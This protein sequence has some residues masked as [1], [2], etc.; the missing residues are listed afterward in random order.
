MLLAG[1]LAAATWMGTALVPAM[2]VPAHL[3][4]VE[5][6]RNLGDPESLLAQTFEWGVFPAPNSLLFILSLGLSPIV[7]VVG[8]GHIVFGLAIAGFVWA[9]AFL[10]A[11][12][13]RSVWIG[14]A[15]VPFAAQWSLTEGFIDYYLGVGLLMVGIGLVLRYR[16]EPTRRGAIGVGAIGALIFLAHVQ[17]LAFYGLAALVLFVAYR[18]PRSRSEWIAWFKQGL[19][20]VGPVLVL[21]LVWLSSSEAV[22][23]LE[24][25]PV[26]FPS[27]EAR[28]GEL[29]TKSV[30]ILESS[31][32]T[33]LLVF[34]LLCFAVVRIIALRDGHPHARVPGAAER[35]LWLLLL[36]TS[37]VFL[38]GPL[39]LGSYWNLHSRTL[40]FLAPL[41]LLIALPRELPR[42]AAPRIASLL[43]LLAPTAVAASTWSRALATW[44][45]FSAGLSGVL[46]QAPKESRI[47]YVVD[48]HGPTGFK[49][50]LWRHLAQ[51]HTVLNQGT[52]TF[53]FGYQ[54]GRIVGERFPELVTE[55]GT[56]GDVPN[57][58]SFGC[59][60]SVLQLGDSDLSRD[61]PAL[62]LVS[63]AGHWA[64][65]ATGKSCRRYVKW[66]GGGG[67]GG[68]PFWL[69]CPRGY[70][71]AGVVGTSAPEGVTSVQAVCQDPAGHEWK[72]PTAGTRRGGTFEALCTS[73]PSTLT[74]GANVELDSSVV[75]RVEV[76]CPG[77]ERPDATYCPAGS[78]GRALRGRA[79]SLIDRLAF[80]CTADP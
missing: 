71:L 41:L 75:R 67:T 48:K 78:H 21:L 3:A 7:G 2:D 33:E 69:E 15:A 53:S 55:F 35:V 9:F 31:G 77:A 56:P 42:A 63:R 22:S 51:Y 36:L 6:M 43:L 12:F 27:L 14:L 58:D 70:R 80:G 13:G 23:N 79:G 44:D 54:K 62:C 25:I 40:V 30:L 1:L 24:S 34:A 47:F 49:S 29:F 16:R 61:N 46:A 32:D 5:A 65:Y 72:S 10:A 66:I 74:V 57:L 20:A 52:T 37:L 73:S 17:A 60:E 45:E 4:L 18:F 68:A 39:N 38:F 50:G 19:V 26:R 11:A 76:A 64:L 8:A 28:F 59:Y